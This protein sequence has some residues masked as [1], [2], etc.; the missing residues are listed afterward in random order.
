MNQ[1]RAALIL[2]AVST[3][4]HGGNGDGRSSYRGDLDDDKPLPVEIILNTDNFPPPPEQ[5]N[6]RPIFVSA[7]ST[8]KYY[9]DPSTL[10]LGADEIVRYVLVIETEGGARNVSFEGLRCRKRAWKLYAMGRPDGSWVKPR[11]SDWRAIDNTPKYRHHAA[12]SRDFFCPN[13]GIIR[14]TEEG[15]KALERGAHPDAN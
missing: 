1:Y 14:S 12:L 10:A 6:L 9:I 15:Q 4:V 13:G 7:E 3:L 5:V 11:A 2:L 8:N